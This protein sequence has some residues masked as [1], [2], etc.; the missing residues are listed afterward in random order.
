M[1]GIIRK[2]NK[3][4]YEA[5]PQSILCTVSPSQQRRGPDLRG[6]VCDACHVA[7]ERAF[8]DNTCTWSISSQRI[9][10]AAE[11]DI[12]SW[13]RKRPTKRTE[14]RCW[15]ARSS[16]SFDHSERPQVRRV[17]PSCSSSHTH[18]LFI[19]YT[20]STVLP[21]PPLSPSTPFLRWTRLT[22][23]PKL[24]KTWITQLV[25]RRRKHAPSRADRSSAS[26]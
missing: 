25:G 9:W 18:P 12:S 8:R 22:P 14:R 13:G 16:L 2:E 20:A 1:R 11:G 19:L 17:R 23:K 21:S 6:A 3:G 7:L 10:G 24:P 5:M 4:T 15:Q 26:I